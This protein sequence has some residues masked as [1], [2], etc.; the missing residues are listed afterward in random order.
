MRIACQWLRSLLDLSDAE[1][2]ALTPARIAGLLTSLGL[3]VEGIEHYGA[4]VTSVVVG[5]VRGKR[6]HPRADR[7]T[8]VE[9][10]DGRE[11]LPVVCGASNV[12][13]VGGK[14]AFAPVG[15]RLPNGVEIAAREVRGER[16]H[17]ML[18]SEV[19]LDVGADGAGILVLPEDLAAGTRLVDAVPG[20][21]D[22]IV[23]LSVTPN[24]PDALG[25]VGV[26]RD[27]AV[28]LGCGLRPGAPAEPRAPAE[29]GLVTLAA[30]E[31]CGRYL[32]FALRG[33]MVGPSPLWLR[34]RLHRLGLRAINNCVDITNLILLEQG[35]P[36]HAFDRAR[37]A[38]GRVVIREAA[39]KEAFEALDGSKH[40]LTPSDLVIADAA[41]PQALAGVMGG[42]PSMVR[43]DTSELLVEVAWFHP[44]GIRASARRHGMATDS[45]YRF[46]RGVDPGE[47]LRR[48]ALRALELF[49]SLTGGVCVAQAEAIG[50]LP[51][52]PRIALRLQRVHHLLGMEVAAEEAA[53]VLSGLGVEV[54]TATPMEPWSCAPPSHRPDLQREVDLIEELM[55]FHGLEHLP[56]AATVPSA[57][58]IE[59]A[60]PAADRRERL[61]DALCEAGLQ[62]H[63]AYAFTSPEK[64]APFLGA[65]GEASIVRLRNPL[66]GPISVMRTSLLPGLLDA[67]EGNAARHPHAVRLFEVGKVYA[68]PEEQVVAGPTKGPRAPAIADVD[69]LLPI[70][71]EQAAIA[72]WSPRG[73]ASEGAQAA[74]GVL[75]HALGRLG[76]A[77]FVTA[78]ARA[79]LSGSEPQV[80]YLHPGVQA[81]VWVVDAT[82]KPSR[83]GRVGE[84]HPDAL[85]GRE[86][87]RGGKIYVGELDLAA[88]PPRPVAR[89]RDVPRFPA[90]SR[91]LSLEI[92]IDLPAH[93]VV[94][95]LIVAEGAVPAAGEDPPRLRGDGFAPAV[96]VIEDYRGAGVPA[97][98]RAL[99]LR[100]HYR[101]TGRSVTDEEVQ[102]RHA[103]V[104]AAACDQ[105]RGRAPEIRVR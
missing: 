29:P 7:L 27:L 5:E 25:H 22:A 94:Q 44:A 78:P 71:P 103:A 13:E 32:G 21:V 46:E 48:A 36:L 1:A 52:R 53:R 56:A 57:P 87:P 91:D 43:A 54:T 58:V 81:L 6:P 30:P 76:Y 28:K 85:V 11:V 40:E 15:T 64:L 9:L 80:A 73:A 90:T 62:Q 12:P 2:A 93:D 49:A 95:S 83:V 55:R 20:I 37:L 39:A 68:W 98:H 41:R 77:A 79:P 104:A 92:P 42:A 60:D 63:V 14:V 19:E 33:V 16:S 31:R 105:L 50:A 26:A 61:I 4:E 59:H 18:C 24:R 97:G 102:A 84:I 65:G 88:L 34:V 45:S 74:V 69:R 38:E 47:G 17:G 66:R 100:L 51:Q 3:E 99:L 96:E 82:G 89:G 70:E 101:A 86:A 23:E 67:L 8:L 35:Q 10:F 75:V 72:L